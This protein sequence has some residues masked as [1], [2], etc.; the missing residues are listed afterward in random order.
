MPELIS[1]AA[2]MA[3]TGDQRCGEPGAAPPTLPVLS[4]AARAAATAQ[5]TVEPL[6][7]IA[8]LTCLAQHR[9][10]ELRPLPGVIQVE[11]GRVLVT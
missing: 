8:G 5:G 7:Q 6:S 10:I 4:S 3:V 2:V 9:R 11:L 1:T